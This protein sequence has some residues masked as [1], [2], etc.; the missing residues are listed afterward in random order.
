MKHHSLKR[1]SF[2]LLIPLFALLTGSAILSSCY[3]DNEEYLYPTIGQSKCDTLSVTYNAN[4]A[5]ILASICNGCHNSL[6]PG[7]NIITDNHPDL[8]TNI[9][10][11]WLSINHF[12]GAE[13]MPKGGGKL[14][15]CDIAKIKRWRTLGMPNN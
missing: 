4:I 9:N 10:K 2:R 7:G 11:I 5:P 14:S 1:K 6:T 13:A 3:Y 15:D 8:V 12:P